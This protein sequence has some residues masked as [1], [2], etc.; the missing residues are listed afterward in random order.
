LRAGAAGAIFALLLAGGARRNRERTMPLPA[1]PPL[2]WLALRLGAA[3]AVVAYASRKALSQPKDP[4]H[5]SVL[6]RMPEGLEG[7]PHRAE[8][9]RAIHGRGR[10]RRVVRLHP[11]GPG[12]EIDAAALARLRFRRV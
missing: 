3:A 12:I 2:A 4:E 9:E 1:V 8:A 7:S 11:S 6:D 5:E 10:F